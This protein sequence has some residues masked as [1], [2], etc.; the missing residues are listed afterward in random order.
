MGNPLFARARVVSAARVN[1]RLTTGSRAASGR[2][3]L[4]RRLSTEQ[5]W[6]I[7]HAVL[8]S[9]DFDRVLVLPI[10]EQVAW[11]TAHD[12]APDARGNQI[13]TKPAKVWLVLHTPHGGHDFLVPLRRDFWRRFLR[14]VSN[15]PFEIK[16]ELRPIDDV[17]ERLAARANP[18]FKASSQS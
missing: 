15:A 1:S 5:L 17:H 18:R 7:H 6:Q 10:K 3:S 2:Q 13:S 4:R 16:P 9:Q 11:V 8:N 14:E 12:Q